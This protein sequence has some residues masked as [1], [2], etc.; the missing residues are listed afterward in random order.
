MDGILSFIISTAND[1]L[2]DLGVISKTLGDKAIDK[3]KETIR[4]SL[5]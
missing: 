3:G 4:K 1:Y 5:F 2:V